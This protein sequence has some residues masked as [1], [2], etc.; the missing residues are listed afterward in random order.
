M[1]SSLKLTLEHYSL[2]LHPFAVRNRELVHTKLDFSMDI[3]ALTMGA[4][5]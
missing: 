1:L 4:F 2:V 3:S 5:L